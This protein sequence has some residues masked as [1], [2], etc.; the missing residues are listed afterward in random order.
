MKFIKA[1][2]KCFNYHG[3]WSEAEDGMM[4]SHWTTAYLEF[5]IKAESFTVRFGRKTRRYTYDLDGV[6]VSNVGSGTD[7][8]YYLDAKKFHTVRISYS[9]SKPFPIYFKGIETDG[10]VKF[11]PASKNYSL[12]IGD[13]L[14]SSIYS[15]SRKVIADQ[16]CD[17]DIIALMGIALCN[18]H[19][20]YDENPVGMETAFFHVECPDEN[21]PLTEIDIK[22]LRTPDEIYINLGLG[23]DLDDE[24][25][26]ENFKKT[27]FEFVTKLNKLWPNAKIYMMLPAFDSE[28]GLVHDTVEAAINNVLAVIKNTEFINSRGVEVEKSPDDNLRPTVAGYEAYSD[29]ILNKLQRK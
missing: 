27:Y 3:R 2:D 1:T 10:E 19:G 5:Q 9:D 26:T 11:A 13:L 21:V 7:S 6:R 15:Y 22:T 24:A 28:N 29:F 23:D 25:N 20:T 4:R 8:T 17:Y 16:N 18:G 14:T 12:F